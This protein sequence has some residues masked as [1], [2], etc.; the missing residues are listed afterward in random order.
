VSSWVGGQEAESIGGGADRR[1]A[2]SRVLPGAG[3]QLGETS[4]SGA[5]PGAEQQLGEA[6]RS[7]RCWVLSSSS[8][9]RRGLGGVGHNSVRR[10]SRGQRR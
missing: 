2:K 7:G 4:R 3:Q 9:R 5:V 1:E 6:P 10:R 8:G